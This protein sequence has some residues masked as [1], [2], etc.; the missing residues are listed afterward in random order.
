MMASDFPLC[1][2]QMISP[3][4]HTYLPKCSDQ[5]AYLYFFWVAV[6]GCL[7]STQ[8]GL[9]TCQESSIAGTFFTVLRIL[10][11]QT[12]RIQSLEIWGPLKC[13][14]SPPE[15]NTH[16]KFIANLLATQGKSGSRRAFSQPCSVFVSKACMPGDLWSGGS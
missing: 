12:A 7:Q 8:N 4:N 10:R 13:L 9:H 1:P 2:N 15:K 14:K 16:T 11:P 3:T 6:S 5:M